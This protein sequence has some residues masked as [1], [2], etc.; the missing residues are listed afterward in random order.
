MSTVNIQNKAKIYEKHGFLFKRGKYTFRT[1]VKEAGGSQKYIETSLMSE[2]SVDTSDVE[3]TVTQALTQFVRDG[4]EQ[5]VMSVEL[6][7]EQVELHLE[8]AAGFLSKWHNFLGGRLSD[9]LKS[10]NPESVL[11]T[12]SWASKVPPPAPVPINRP[13]KGM[14]WNATENPILNDTGS[15]TGYEDGWVFANSTDDPSVQPA[16]RPSHRP[17]KDKTWNVT[18]TTIRNSS[19]GLKHVQEC[20]YG[21]TQAP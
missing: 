8:Y 2:S 16:T 3:E 17:P 1:V 20:R 12:L 13:P 14:V 11:A 21:A 19:T 4:G 10:K 15:V 5:P 7:Q 9:F 6:L 18:T